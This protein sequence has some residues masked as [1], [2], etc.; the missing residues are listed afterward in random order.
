[1][2][3]IAIMLAPFPLP[4]AAHRLSGILAMTVVFWV[5]EALPLPMTAMLGPVLAVLFGIAPAKAAFASFAD[6][7]IFVFIGSF[8]LAE[9]MFVHGV[10][11]RIA[12]TALSSRAVG[13]SALRILVVFGAVTTGLSMWMSNTAT[14]AMMFPIGLSIAAHL[15]RGQASGSDAPR[16]FA[17]GLMLMTSFGAS[18]GGIGTPV[19]TPP[20]LIGIGMLERLG[21]VKVEF[22]QWMLL[23]APALLLLF[24]YLCLN[25]GPTA[26]GLS[27]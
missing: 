1:M 14:T 3:M 20:N 15:V 17:M 19:G 8:I 4:P 24:G 13:S 21:G 9:A 18:I 2:L 23:C 6:P 10:D 7:V 16:R 12:F 25:L 5:T 27:V 26:R 22:F 11:R